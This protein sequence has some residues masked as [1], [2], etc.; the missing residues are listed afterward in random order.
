MSRTNDLFSSTQAPAVPRW[1][2]RLEKERAFVRDF[3]SLSPTEWRELLRTRTVTSA[4]HDTFLSLDWPH[5]CANATAACGGP[6]GWCYT[7]QGR[8]ATSLHNRHAA[9]VDVLARQDPAL[10]AEH[11]Y[12]EVNRAVVAGH[13]PYRNIRFSGS[14]EMVEKHVPAIAAVVQSGVHA[15]GFTRTLRVAERLREVGAYVIVSC[16]ATSPQGFPQAPVEA[17]FPLAY[18]SS[19]VNDS[20][21]EGTLVTFP[22][23]RVGRVREAVDTDSLC[24]KVVS[25]FLRDERPTSFCQ[26][27]CHRCHRGMEVK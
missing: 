24:P 5:Y 21:P 19:G 1:R 9:M 16:D 8:Q 2:K 22:V 20:P 13:M 15:W 6:N 3:D 11:V 7:F 10:F 25:E 12:A 14:G 18:S 26:V 17:G 23:H 27:L 4:N